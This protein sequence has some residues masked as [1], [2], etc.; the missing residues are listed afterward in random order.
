MLLELRKCFLAVARGSNCISLA[1]KKNAK[2]PS[3]RR[4]VFGDEYL[5]AR[6]HNVIPF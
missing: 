5:S 2:A 1:L 3:C 4:F 6:R